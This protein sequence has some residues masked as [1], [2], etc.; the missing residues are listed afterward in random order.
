MI[1]PGKGTN[2]VRAVFIIDPN[3]LVRL[4]IYYPQEIGRQV[5]EVLEHLELY[6]MLIKTKWQCLKTG[7]TTKY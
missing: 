5:D 1:H 6:S 3:G 2:T 4:M 7:P